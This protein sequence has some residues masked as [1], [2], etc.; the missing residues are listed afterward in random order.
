MA[1]R[2]TVVAAVV[3][4][5]GKLLLTSRPENKPPFGLE[6]PG[7]KVDKGETFS[8][9]LARELREELDVNAIILD[10]IYKMVKPNMDLWFIRAVIP[11]SETI[12][13]CEEQEFF[14]V[15]PNDKK[16]LD[17]LFARIPLLPGDWKFW[18]FLYGE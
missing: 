9:A 13:C 12:R 3:R 7:G 10:P 16:A 11:E 8:T 18:N 1:D 6:F 14:W 2:I 4:R 17:E 5:G 15:D